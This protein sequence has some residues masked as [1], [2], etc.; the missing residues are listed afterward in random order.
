MGVGNGYGMGQGCDLWMQDGLR[1]DRYGDM[2]QGDCFMWLG[3]VVCGNLT[4]LLR[5]VVNGHQSLAVGQ[6]HNTV[7]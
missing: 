2:L 7:L 5:A 3:T 4:A 6:L 1:G